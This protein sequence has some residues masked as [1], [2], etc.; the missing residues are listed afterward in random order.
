MPTRHDYRRSYTPRN[1]VR[2]RPPITSR[3]NAM[4]VGGVHGL[5]CSRLSVALGGP[6]AVGGVVAP[7]LG[8]VGS[9]PA[10]LMGAV[11]FGAGDFAGSRASLRLDGLSA[12]AVSQL[13]AAATG[14][15][16]IALTG[17]AVPEGPQRA[18]AM[19]AG[20]FHVA[21]V[22]FIYQGMARGRVS[23]VA[24]VAGVVGIGVPVFADMIFIEMARAV[25]CAG[26]VLA[27]AAI[28]LISRSSGEED[29][30]RKHFS[31]RFG[32]AS[33]IGYGLADLCLGLM[34]VSTAE[35][36][37]AVARLSGASLSIGLLCAY[38]LAAEMAAASRT[39]AMWIT[40]PGG[41]RSAA[42]HVRRG[43]SLPQLDANAAPALLLCAT[44]GLLDCIGQLGYVL[45]ATQGQM[46]IAAALVAMYPAV[47]VGLAVWLLGERLGSAQ[48]IGFAASLCS[49]VLLTQ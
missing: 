24:P 38:W 30:S 1:S 44:A 41:A 16:V 5:P 7:V 2:E 20:A 46:S 33:G 39:R 19:I 49:I 14:L 29:R 25:H 13:V 3:L 21:A 18:L 4:T 17:G 26:I 27:A 42:G 45:S 48:M 22:F 36:G 9:V 32:L 34:T 15:V 31:V 12:V 37:L 10:G 8:E 43:G 6:A 11:A 28:V 47:S 35:G 40:P 23:V